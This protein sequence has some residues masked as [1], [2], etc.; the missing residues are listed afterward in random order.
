M[1]S[2]TEDISIDDLQ[3]VNVVGTSG[4]GKSTFA[5]RLAELLDA[6]CI[7]MDRLYHKPNWE[8]STSEELVASLN[9]AL[10]PENWVLDGNY[11]SKS[12]QTKWARATCIIWLDMSFA[13]TVTQAFGRAIERIRTKKELWPGTG[14]RETFRRTFLSRESILLWT[15][16][17]YHRVHARYT[18]VEQ[19]RGEFNHVRFVRLSGRQATEQF[20]GLVATKRS[21]SA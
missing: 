17:S 7:E 6:P 12:Y 13:R 14:N 10:K 1:S 4:S 18:A 11:H 9:E 16:T 15:L 3:R 21:S 5:K 2:S 20:L 19:E 8:E